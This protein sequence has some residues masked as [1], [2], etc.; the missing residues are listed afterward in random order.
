MGSAILGSAISTPPLD[1][2]EHAVDLQRA[3]REDD[4]GEAEQQRLCGGGRGCPSCARRGSPAR[5]LPSAPGL[6]RLA[7]AA[8]S[9]AGGLGRAPGGG[10]EARLDV[11]A[12][13]L[14][15]ARLRAAVRRGTAGPRL[16]QDLV[17]RR[18]RRRVGF[19]EESGGGGIG[20]RGRASR[21]ARRCGKAERFEPADLRLGPR[22]PRRLRLLGERRLPWFPPPCP[23]APWRGGGRGPD[24]SAGAAPGS[25]EA[26]RVTS[27]SS[28]VLH[29]GHRVAAHCAPPTWEA[30]APTIR[31][32]L[33]LLYSAPGGSGSRAPEYTSTR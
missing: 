14:L 22:R 18:R 30:S 13:G 31:A 3:D 2:P 6:S 28:V 27:A 32:L 16:E 17:E 15:G 26:S 1:R 20:S 4:R 21:R 23:R 8:A 29:R 5:R 25:S 12:V 33:L 11:S 24:R 7:A 19:R 9:A 10:D